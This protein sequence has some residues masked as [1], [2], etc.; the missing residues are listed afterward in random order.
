MGAAVEAFLRVYVTAF[1]LFFTFCTPF[2]FFLLSI[3]LANSAFFSRF[4]C[5]A[6]ST[7][8]SPPFLTLEYRE[9]K[10]YWRCIRFIYIGVIT[11]LIV[12][13]ALWAFLAAIDMVGIAA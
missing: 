4:V 11:S 7:P 1:S 13:Q 12:F 6:P 3:V 10:K 9:W 5:P 8:L 2:S